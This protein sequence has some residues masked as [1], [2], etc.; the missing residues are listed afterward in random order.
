MDNST[1]TTQKQQMDD[2]SQKMDELKLNQG[3]SLIN[4]MV[5]DMHISQPQN[6]NLKVPETFK[7]G[8]V[9]SS[10]SGKGSVVE[11]K[12]RK[13]SKNKR[14]KLKLYRHR[15]Y[16]HKLANGKT[17]FVIEYSNAIPKTL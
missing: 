6:Y 14:L 5:K 7:F 4:A 1:S 11:E 10:F 16:A 15:S 2:L 9:S 12:T 17:Q 13:V 8:A 3:V